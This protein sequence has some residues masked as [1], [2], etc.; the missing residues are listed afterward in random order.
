MGMGNLAQEL[1]RKFD[2]HPLPGVY[3]FISCVKILVSY[4]AHRV[5]CGIY[6]A[7]SAGKCHNTT[8]IVHAFV[9]VL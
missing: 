9:Y 1:R 3:I 7:A 8:A 4:C 5:Y 2:L 6:H